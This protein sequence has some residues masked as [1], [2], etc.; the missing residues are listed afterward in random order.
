MLP[1]GENTEMTIPVDTSDDVKKFVPSHATVFMGMPPT[2]LN[3]A[4]GRPPDTSASVVQICSVPWSVTM[5][6]RSAC[7]VFACAFIVV[8][9]EGARVGL[10]L[11]VTSQILTVG[12]LLALAPPTTAQY[13]PSLPFSDATRTAVTSSPEPGSWNCDCIKLPGLA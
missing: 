6:M 7:A 9:T 11:L 10:A 5:P 13:R 2:P 8:R 4:I 12:K 3:S 1:E